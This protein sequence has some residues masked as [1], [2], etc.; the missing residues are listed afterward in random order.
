MEAV[1]ENCLC[2]SGQPVAEIKAL[3]SGP[4][5]AMSSADEAGGLEPLLLLATG[6]C[7]ILISG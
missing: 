3:H 4:N 2:S 7:L 1:V 5:A 6:A